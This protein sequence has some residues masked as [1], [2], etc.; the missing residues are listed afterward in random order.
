[1]RFWRRSAGRRICPSAAGAPIPKGGT[2]AG[3]TFWA[4]TPFD[5]ET[6]S[7]GNGT[8]VAFP[9]RTRAEVD[10]F[11]AT[12][13]AMGGTDEGASGPR[14]NYG[15]NWYSA[16]MRDPS[17]NKIAAYL[18]R[19][20]TVIAE[21]QLIARRHEAKTLTLR[22]DIANRGE[23]HVIA[24]E[25]HAV[26]GDLAEDPSAR[27]C[28]HGLVGVVLHIP[29]GVGERPDVMIGRVGR[30]DQHLSPAIN[31]ITHVAGRMA[32]GFHREHTGNRAAAVVQKGEFLGQGRDIGSE[33]VRW[34]SQTNGYARL[35]RSH[36]GHWG[37]SVRRR[38]SARRY[39]R[40]AC[41]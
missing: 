21:H 16:Y 12:A 8:M 35:R 3:F 15:A 11:H 2:G 31:D 28:G 30:H 32:E 7:V 6:A 9:A 29:V 10:R 23:G 17:G 19:P 24:D 34:G 5:G 37:T 41:G 22:L 14:E 36:S 25:G 1:M 39:G 13:L 26:R 33:L 27:F 4:C 40:D 38:S 18:N 20:D